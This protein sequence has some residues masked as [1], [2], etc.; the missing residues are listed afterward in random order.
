MGSQQV[1]DCN[2]VWDGG[3]FFDRPLGLGFNRE[4]MEKILS[5]VD[6]LLYGM[7]FTMLFVLSAIGISSAERLTRE[8]SH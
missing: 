1:R 5:N 4:K 7:R 2:F 8:I 3:Y 6:P